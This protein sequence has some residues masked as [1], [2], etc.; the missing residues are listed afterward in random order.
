MLKTYKAV[1]EQSSAMNYS[2]DYN[3]FNQIDL[4]LYTVFENMLACT[5]TTA[6]QSLYVH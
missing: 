5:H 3:I 4:E 1:C 6:F 2:E